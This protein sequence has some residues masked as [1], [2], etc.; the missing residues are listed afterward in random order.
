M[1]AILLLIVLAG[2]Y[3]IE[4]NNRNLRFYE[5][6]EGRAL[7]VAE[8]HLAQDNM[9][10]ENFQEVLKKYPQ[11][12][13]GEAI[14]IYNDQY[15]PVFI[16]ED[17]LH[18]P[19]SLIKEVIDE[20]RIFFNKG[21]QQVV[22]LYYVDNSG[23]F[24][25]IASAIDDVGKESMEKL[26]WIMLLSFAASLFITFFLGRIFASVTLSPIVNIIDRVKI[27]R[28]TSLNQRLPS[29]IHNN[30]EIDQLSTTINNLLEHLE[31]SFQDQQAFITNASHELKT[32]LTSILGTSEISLKSDRTTEEYKNTLSTIIKETEKLTTVL[33]S[34]LELAQVTMDNGVLER[35][36]LDELLWGVIDEIGDKAGPVKVDYGAPHKDEKYTIQGNPQL[37]FIA[38]SNILKNALKF[39]GGK[40]VEC[41]LYYQDKG[42]TIS[43]RDNGI[44]IN[45]ND[46][47]KI[48]QPFYRAQNAYGFPGSGIGLSLADK[49]IRLHNGT[50]NVLSELGK[51]T[52]F[53]ISFF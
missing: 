20:K 30:D 17:S 5:K 19:V 15:Q 48:F 25:V 31:Q 14:R 9:S 52:E 37:L 45:S 29:G 23:N 46:I 33:N 6:L 26:G 3:I 28:A 2:I 36:K 13:S 41:K 8:L 4:N 32:P 42:V 24:V 10:K 27:I 51:G 16:K 11:S 12:L 1:F 47:E 34:L 35:V 39:S 7:I 44:G 22:G 18:W 53:R 50:I 49:I 38:F 43:I 21:D 40:E